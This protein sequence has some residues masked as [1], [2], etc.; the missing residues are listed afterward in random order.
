MI[1]YNTPEALPHISQSAVIIIPKSP[2]ISSYE[3]MIL[4]NENCLGWVLSL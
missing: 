2:S 1:M 3:Q 4:G